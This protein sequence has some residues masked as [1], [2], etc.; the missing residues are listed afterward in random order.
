MSKIGHES[1][2][3]QFVELRI[4]LYFPHILEHVYIVHLFLVLEVL[5]FCVNTA[6]RQCLFLPFD[7]I[8]YDAVFE[9]FFLH[10]LTVFMHCVVRL[11]FFVE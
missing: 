2:L 8:E 6:I 4:L 11:E 1:F 10:F 9:I 7:F 5:F 3:Q